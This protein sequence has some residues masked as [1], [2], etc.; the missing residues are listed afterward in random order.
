MYT[1]G[2]LPEGLPGV[3]LSLAW[4][5]PTPVPVEASFTYNARFRQYRDTAEGSWSRTVDSFS[6][7]FTAC[8]A[9][10]AAGRLRFSACAGIATTYFEMTE[11]SYLYDPAYLPY[12][13]QWGTLM[14]SPAAEVRFDVQIFS[15]LRARA[16]FGGM[17]AI[18]PPESTVLFDPGFEQPF[19][20]KLTE[21]LIFR[22]QLGIEVVIPP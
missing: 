11:E 3:R 4:L 6:L 5:S 14:V 22:G 17:V 2:M 12:Y 19:D 21:P 9:N 18:N 8:P 16:G 15:W 7:E 20:S 1:T 13:S 10:V